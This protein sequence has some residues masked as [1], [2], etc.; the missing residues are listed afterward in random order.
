MANFTS[1]LNAMKNKLEPLLILESYG[2]LVPKGMETINSFLEALSYVGTAEKFQ[3]AQ[4][5]LTSHMTDATKSLEEMMKPA[6]DAGASLADSVLK[7]KQR[8]D[9]LKSRYLIREDDGKVR[10]VFDKTVNDHIVFD[11]VTY[12]LVCLIPTIEMAISNGA[13]K[14]QGK[15]YKF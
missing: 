3:N 10:I 4:A 9:T 11:N 2:N 7:V 5:E 13:D 12:E 15:F 6:W 14:T 1:E 8:Y